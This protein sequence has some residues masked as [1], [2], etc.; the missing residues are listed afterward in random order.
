MDPLTAFSL[1]CGVIQVVDFSTKILGKCKEIYETGSLSQH[2]DVED[3]TKH[4]TGLQ[5]ELRQSFLS[6]HA[7]ESETSSDRNL[8]ELAGNCSATADQLISKLDSLK[9]QGPNSKRKA[10]K[11]AMRSFWESKDIESIR[12]RL[13]SDREM[14]DT[15]VLINLRFVTLFMS[16]W[17]GEDR[18]RKMFN[19]IRRIVKLQIAPKTEQQKLCMLTPS[20]QRLDLLSVREKHDFKNLDQK[21]QRLRDS[22]AQGMETF[23]QV[24]VLVQNESDRT[25]EHVS[26]EFEKQKRQRESEEHRRLLLDSLWFPEIHSREE[27]IADAHRKTFEWVFD[28]SGLGVKP[29]DDFMQWLEKGQGTYWIHGKAGSGK[30]TLMSFLVQDPRTLQAL[31]VWSGTKAVFMPKFFFWI[32]GTVMEKSIEGL[33]RSLIWQ[34]MSQFPSVDH[35]F[36]DSTRIAVWTQRRLREVLIDLVDEILGTC[37]LCFFIDGLDE[38]YG[39]QDELIGLVD[40][41]VQDTDVKI[42]LSSRPY[43]VFDEAFGS[44]AKLRLQDLTKGDIWRYVSDKLETLS[45]VDSI[46]CEDP[47]WLQW[48]MKHIVERSQGVFLW[49]TLAVKD[50]I[51]GLKNED[52]PKQL[53]DR[54][55]DLPIEVEGVYA[56]MLH[57]IDKPYREE[58]A[59]CLQIALHRSRMSLLEFTLASH[60]DLDRI[61]HT[62]TTCSEDKIVAASHSKKRRI[63][64]TC[65]GLLEITESKAKSSVFNEFAEHDPGESVDQ[66]SANLQKSNTVNWIHRTAFDFMISSEQGK[67]FLSI[68]AAKGFV[69]EIAYCKVLLIKARLFGLPGP[70]R[71]GPRGEDIIHCMKSM[72]E[73]GVRQIGLWRLIDST[74]SSIYRRFPQRTDEHWTTEWYITYVHSQ[75]KDYT[76]RLCIASRGTTAGRV[77]QS[78]PPELVRPHDFL[79]LMASLSFKQYVLHEIDSEEGNLSSERAS[80]LLYCSILAITRFNHSQGESALTRACELSRELLNRMC[81]ADTGVFSTGTSC[82]QTFWGKYLRRLIAVLS[83]HDTN[84]SAHDRRAE[85]F[86]QTAKVFIGHQASVDEKW[87]LFVDV[88]R[89]SETQKV[90]RF[91]EFSEIPRQIVKGRDIP[92]RLEIKISTLAIFDYCLGRQPGYRHL[93][94]LCVTKGAPYYA[95]ATSIKSYDSEGRSR[96]YE[97][98]EEDSSIMLSIWRQ[99]RRYMKL[100]QD[101]KPLLYKQIDTFFNEL[102]N[103]TRGKL[104][105][106]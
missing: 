77:Y 5:G 29:W 19:I 97:L 2:R 105:E 44:Q 33:L 39:D 45:Q 38:F 51:K 40:E 81:D 78:T 62:F 35:L 73:A 92:Y 8:L 102:E 75:K 60:E 23:E 103:G 100:S 47:N 4:L 95:R 3:V 87:K 96:R 55:S 58:A 10:I 93:R 6:Q 64:S 79:G 54:L 56:R 91:A 53:T 86:L 70:S 98:S 43:R 22:L 49:V 50:Q 71:L 7:T 1:A 99:E 13:Q 84:C 66:E 59:R 61:V 32:S 90:L 46:A 82:Y 94:D 30:S 37:H 16:N 57:E 52:S 31:S 20:R 65:G 88:E 106:S 25:R 80:Y 104:I 17:T 26:I 34:M 74:V 48:H 72:E 15:Y 21:V 36:L 42:C 76:T 12:D 28:R 68:N 67:A 27:R 18:S 89:P 69:P 24:K 14:L 85:T 63:M 9:I 11:M 83:A 41:L 101:E